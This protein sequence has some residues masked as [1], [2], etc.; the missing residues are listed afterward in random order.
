MGGQHGFPTRVR[1]SPFQEVVRVQ[2]FGQ[3]DRAPNLGRLGTPL[4]TLGYPFWESGERRV[5][6]GGL[7]GGAWLTYFS[8]LRNL[9]SEISSILMG[10]REGWGGVRVQGET[11]R[12]EPGGRR[13]MIW[14]SDGWEEV[15]G[16]RGPPPSST[17][18]RG[19]R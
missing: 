13:D 7:G 3:L 15:C 12:W 11:G 10:P 1:G 14:Q 6:G 18:D 8:S 16:I 5:L 4:A 9:L 17:Q 19:W 2:L